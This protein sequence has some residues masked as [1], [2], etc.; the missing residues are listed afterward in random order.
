MGKEIYQSRNAVEMVTLKKF[1]KNIYL[2][3]IPPNESKK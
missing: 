2:I 1:N 3:V